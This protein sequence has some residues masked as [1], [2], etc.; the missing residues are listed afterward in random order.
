MNKKAIVLIPFRSG[1]R[2]YF[3]TQQVESFR[4]S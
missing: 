2:R 1:L 3:D 4:Q